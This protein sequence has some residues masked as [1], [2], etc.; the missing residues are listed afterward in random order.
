MSEVLLQLGFPVGIGAAGGFIAGHAVKKISK[1]IA[2]IVGLFIA[3][4]FT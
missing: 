4:L 1:L 2:V 3:A